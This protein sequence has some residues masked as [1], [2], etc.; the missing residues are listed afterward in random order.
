MPIDKSC[1][2]VRSQIR[3]YLDSGA[4][5]GEFSQALGVS[6]NSLNNFLRQN[7]PMKGSGSDAYQEAW[8]FFKRREIAGVKKP[9]KKQKSDANEQDTEE[10]GTSGKD[11][12]EKK[13]KAS[14][15]RKIKE[16][17]NSAGVDISGVQLLGEESD[18]VPVQDT[19]DEI[20]R[21][22]NAHLKQ[23]GVTQAQFCRDMQGMLQSS[24][25][26]S[27]IQGTQLTS[28]RSKKGPRA[29]ATSSVYYAAFV[30]FEKE[31]IAKG[32]KKTKHRVEM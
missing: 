21:K 8:A 20:R 17:G 4:K 26:A 27:K 32:M 29:G 7:G 28:F 5:V 18:S 16:A 11:A 15:S 2:Q 23:E 1:N 13:A 3:R 12:T 6:S 22:I 14:A 24:G 19:C 25:G 31:R 9:T 30:F 10:K